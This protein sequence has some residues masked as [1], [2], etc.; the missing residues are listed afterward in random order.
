MVTPVNQN[1]CFKIHLK[2]NGNYDFCGSKG[3][4]LF[5]KTR[6]DKKA[7]YYPIFLDS[8]PYRVTQLELNGKV[9]ISE[10]F[11]GFFP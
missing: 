10:Y 2:D 6:I 11:L 4:S 1:T 5:E 9:S 8:T 3:Q 7:K